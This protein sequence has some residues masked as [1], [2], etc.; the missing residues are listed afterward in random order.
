MTTAGNV[1]VLG[2]SR[3][4]CNAYWIS[5]FNWGR[6]PPSRMISSSVVV[7]SSNLRAKTSTSGRPLTFQVLA[8][9]WQNGSAA[10]GH[11]WQ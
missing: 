9:L 5:S 11:N 1:L 2:W 6:S 3:R 10:C 8:W 4:H 7:I